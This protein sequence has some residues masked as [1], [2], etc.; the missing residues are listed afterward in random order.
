MLLIISYCIIIHLVICDTMILLEGWCHI[1][2][3]PARLVSYAFLYTTHLASR[4]YYCSPLRASP[5]PSHFYEARGM[6]EFRLE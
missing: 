2:M 1:R 3:R 4:S 5:F 6:L